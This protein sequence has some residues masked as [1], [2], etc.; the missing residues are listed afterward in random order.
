VLFV[1]AQ[2]AMSQARTGKGE[3]APSSSM[4]RGDLA[5]TG[6]YDGPAIT[7]LPKVKWAFKT[8]G[9]IFSSPAIVENLAYIGSTDGNLYALDISDGLLADA[10]HLAEA[11]GL[12]V[13]I[14]LD[15]MPL[16]ASAQTWLAAQPDQAAAL[17]DLATGGDDYQ[18]AIGAPLAVPGFTALGRFVEGRGVSV[19][20][21]GA[22]VEVTRLGWRHV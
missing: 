4:F 18:L 15:R 12:A 19:T 21:A 16:S 3:A 1:L 17:L 9:A 6:A 14:D 20:C 13:E 11:S 5:H 7:A 8:G 10:G 2:I 22:P